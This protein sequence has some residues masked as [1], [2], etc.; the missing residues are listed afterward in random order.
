M[1]RKAGNKVA[2]INNDVYRGIFLCVVI[3]GKYVGR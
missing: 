2:L 1:D 3:E